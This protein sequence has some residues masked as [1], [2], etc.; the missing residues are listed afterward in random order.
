MLTANEHI[1]KGT[2][3]PVAPVLRQNRSFGVQL[4]DNGRELVDVN[5]CDPYARLPSDLEADMERCWDKRRLEA[6]ITECD[7]CVVFVLETQRAVLL[8]AV[9]PLVPG[10]PRAG[11]EEYHLDAAVG[12]QVHE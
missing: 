11:A 4:F 8:K 5:R 1:R 6:L 9:Q 10:T 3:V 12:I 2:D 7:R